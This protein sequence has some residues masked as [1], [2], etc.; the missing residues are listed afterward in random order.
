VSVTVSSSLPRK[1]IDRTHWFAVATAFFVTIL[2]SSSFIIIKFGLLEIPPLIFAGL[3]YSIASLI[4]LMAAI[5]MSSSRNEIKQLSKNWWTKLII[6]GLVYYSITMGTQFLGLAFLPALMV[7]FI[8][9]FT[10]IIVVL[11][12]FIFLHEQPN[13]KQLVLVIIA[14]VGGF[15][16]FWPLDLYASSLFG[17]LIVGVSLLANSFSAI[18]GRNIN[19]NK[20]VSALVVTAIS[21]SFGSLLLLVTGF[22]L[23]PTILLSWWGLLT[24]LWLSIVNT[25]L[26]FT[27]WNKA[28][29]RLTAL[30]TSIIN[31]TMLAQ[32]AILAIIFLGEIPTIIQWIC[33]FTVMVAAMLIPILR[34]SNTS[35][36]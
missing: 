9:N 17:I 1:R 6:Y 4:L 10:T 35:S 8:L 19:R 12:A 32:I 14:F 23:T 28:M 5:G 18:I 22:I 30:E 11:L 15:F 20:E 3:R 21:M 29:Q 7:S 2:W 36:D 25:A 13:W 34:T 31:S 24:I 27:L 26:A 16:Y 33:I